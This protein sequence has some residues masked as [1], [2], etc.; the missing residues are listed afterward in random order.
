MERGKI[1]IQNNN[2][3]SRSK[4]CRQAIRE[5]D[6]IVIYKDPDQAGINLAYNTRL[7]A[8]IHMQLGNS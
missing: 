5:P 2:K 6:Q 8:C 1:C 3:I 7:G 4:D